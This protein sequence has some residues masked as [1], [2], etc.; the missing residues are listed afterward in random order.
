MV[1]SDLSDALNRNCL[2]I[3]ADVPSLRSWLERDLRKHGLAVPIVETHPHLFSP[4]PVFVAERHAR[5]MQT[6]I[7]AI[8]TVVATPAYR[9]SALKDAPPIARTQTGA[10]GVFFG[11]DFHLCDSG[12]QLIEINTNAGGAMLNVALSRAQRA[13]CVEVESF[14]RAAATPDALEHSFVEMFK[15]EWRALRGDRKLAHIAIVDDGPTEQ[16]LY[17]EFLLFQRLFAA[18]GFTASVVDSRE[19]RYQNGVVIAGDRPIDLIYSRITDFYFQEPHHAVLAQAYVDGA[20]V[21]T[22]DPHAHALYANKRNL[23]L[24]TDERELRA[25]RIDEPTIEIL[26][27]GIPAT[28]IVSAADEAQWWS[29]RKQWFFKPVHGF[30]SRGSYRGDKL[31]RKVFS[32]ILQRDYV[33]QRIVQ[34][35]ERWLST[36]QETH[37][38][39]VDLRNYVYAGETQLLA[40]RLYRG[41]TTNF[42]TPGGG[43]AAVYVAPENLN[44]EGRC[45]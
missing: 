19:L 21:I 9:E 26:L 37:P 6:I 30:G 28:R 32:E 44:G 36:G 17:P 1:T 35:S 12:P 2:C 10:R 42:R 34:P 45:S 11:Y 38:L 4:T 22:P 27:R 7:R 15:R 8:E 31:T 40:A 3:G 14:F 18:H 24:L 39:K 5:Q 43:F 33:A 20:V 41:Q 29:E 13:C 23:A 16:Y 25:M